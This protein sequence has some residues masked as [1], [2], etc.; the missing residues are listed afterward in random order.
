MKLLVRLQCLQDGRKTAFGT[1]YRP[2]WRSDRKP[3]L[4]GAQVALPRSVPLL[5]PGGTAHALLTPFDSTL[6]VVEVGDELRG[7]EGFKQTVSG[8]VLEVFEP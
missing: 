8:V 7:Y 6:W 2:D 1:G 4:N 5:A 3:E